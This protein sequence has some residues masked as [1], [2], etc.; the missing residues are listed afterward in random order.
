MISIHY[1]HRFRLLLVALCCLFSSDLH[2]IGEEAPPNIPTQGLARF[3]AVPTDEFRLRLRHLHTGES[4]D[5][6]YR[7]GDAY[8]ESGIAM[9]NHFLRDSRTNEDAHY[10]VKEFDLLHSI[11]G[12]LHRPNSTIEIICGY[13]SP[14]SNEYLRTLGEATGVAEHSQHILSKAIDLRVPGVG[15]RHLRDVALS[16]GLGGVGYYPLSH[17]VHVDVGPV[18]Q[19]SFGE[20]RR[21]FASRRVGHGRRAARNG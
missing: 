4:I 2:A 5:V 14:Q 15:T 8:L 9:L 12:I 16:L 10:D 7:R 18:R 19:W 11:M 17:F 20:R 21:L 13:R 1:E 6:A 3:H